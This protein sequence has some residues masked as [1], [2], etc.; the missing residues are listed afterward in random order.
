MLRCIELFN[1][2]RQ[3]FN[4]GQ[5]IG[6][7]SILLSNFIHDSHGLINFPLQVG[8]PVAALTGFESIQA[9]LNDMLDIIEPLKDARLAG[10]RPVLLEEVVRVSHEE[11]I[12]LFLCL[13][14]DGELVPDK[15]L[16]RRVVL[17]V[18]GEVLAHLD[19]VG[20]I[21]EHFFFVC[22]GKFNSLIGHLLSVIF[23]LAK[24][25]LHLLILMLE[26]FIFEALVV[27]FGAIGLRINI[28]KAE[29]ADDAHAAVEICLDHCYLIL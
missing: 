27:L 18:L 23:P 8:D 17:E 10:R 29:R 19:A 21:L 13:R 11:A 14:D 24:E 5:P 4:L 9:S 7:Q 26:Y 12:R 16:G 3:L 20:A 2:V 1:F 22:L 6:T 25:M 15:L 28:D